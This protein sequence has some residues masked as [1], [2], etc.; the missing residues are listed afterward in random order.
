[1]RLLPFLWS[2]R[3]TL[4]VERNTQ[5]DEDLLDQLQRAA[6]NYFLEEINP[7][8]GLMADTSRKDAP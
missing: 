8:N 7:A 5:S 2:F 6:F 3:S 1:M 4:V